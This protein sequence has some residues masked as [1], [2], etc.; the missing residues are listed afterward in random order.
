MIDNEEAPDALNV[1]SAYDPEHRATPLWVIF[2]HVNEACPRVICVLVSDGAPTVWGYSIWKR[3]P[4]F[5]TL[6][7]SLDSFIERHRDCIFFARKED[8][9]AKL[10][11]LMTPAPRLAKE[12][13]AKKSIQNARDEAWAKTLEA[14]PDLC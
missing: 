9:L 8:A 5:R 7:I 14:H 4:G 12:I 13:A 3:S 11:E 1:I 10:S 2:G 6:G